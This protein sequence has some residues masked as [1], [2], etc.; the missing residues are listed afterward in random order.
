MTDTIYDLSAARTMALAA[1]KLLEPD[2]DSSQ[3]ADQEVIFQTVKKLG[4]VQIDTLH[5]VQ[6][7]H[8]LVLW[9]RLGSYDP[10]DFDS[11]VYSAA[12]RRLFEGWQHAASIIP[13]EDYRFQIPHQHYVRQQQLLAGGW[14]VEPA[15]NELLDSV[16]TRIKSEGALRARDF[17]YDGP[18]RGSW[19]DWKPAKNALELLYSW[20]DLMI[21]NRINFQRMY[22]LRQRVL[23][24]WVDSSEPTDGER[25]RF[26]LEQGA[27]ALG[28]CQPAQAA[29]Y[30]YRKRNFVRL[31]LR[32]MI[33]EGLF[34]EVQVKVGD[35]SIKS[36]IIHKEN[37]ETL[38]RIADGEIQAQRTTFLSPFDSLFWARGRDQEFWGFRNL[39]EAYKPAPTRIWGYF[40]M[41]ILHKDKLIGRIDPKIDRKNNLLIVR[42]IF[43]EQNVDLHEG[44]IADLAQ[45]FSSFM[46]FHQAKEIIFE[47]KKDK[48]IGNRI[49]AAL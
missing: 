37:V 4:C 10:A 23:P 20:G 42:S 8:Y 34:V 19:W 36:F 44:T 14:L 7:S 25:D 30:S 43:I 17:K 3:H 12:Q 1:Q 2:H 15:N 22:D 18:K 46:R 47:N 31:H 48:E 16:Y 24:E 26:W 28:L 33:A 29:D 6:R 27:R 9:S 21:A 35:G 32:D 38:E 40:N 49:L 13:L 5:V 41:P 45:A 11:L 39:L